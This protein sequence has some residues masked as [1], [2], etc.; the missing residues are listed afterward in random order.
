MRIDRPA[1]FRRIVRHRADA[2]RA[3]ARRGPAPL[4]GRN[5]PGAAARRT[6]SQSVPGLLR[7]EIA[8]PRLR[9]QPA[10][11]ALDILGS[12]AC[13]RGQSRADGEPAVWNG[14]SAS[15]PSFVRWRPRGPARTEWAVGPPLEATVRGLRDA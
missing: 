15:A 6:V 11:A 9:R 4:D 10:R 7:R 8:P 3:G 5:T 13:A 2:R 1:V 14:P 12:D